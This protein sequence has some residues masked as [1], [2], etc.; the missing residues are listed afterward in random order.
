MRDNKL[1]ENVLNTSEPLASDAAQILM[2][3]TYDTSYGLF[4]HADPRTANPLSPVMLHPGEQ[5]YKEGPIYQA[6]LRYER[7]DILDRFGLSLT[8]YLDLPED[9]VTMLTDITIE[10]GERDAKLAND[11]QKEP[12]NADRSRGAWRPTHK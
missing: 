2:D 8:E 5:Y 1:F 12:P 7:Q 9:Y 6:I 3:M 4:D 11:A 10:L